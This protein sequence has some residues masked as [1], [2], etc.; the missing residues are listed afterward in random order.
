MTD[1]GLP[2]LAEA[3]AELARTGTLTFSARRRLWEA[4]G[5]YEA[6]PE[7]DPAPRTLTEPLQGRAM[8][9]LACARKVAPLWTL[10]APG[11]KRAERLI[12]LTGSYL[13]GKY[14]A[15][16]LS[17][18]RGVI[19]EFTALRNSEPDNPA[20]AAAIAAWKALM[21]ALYD[22]Q[23]LEPRYANAAD[24]DL[25]PSDW[26][27]ARNACAVWQEAGTD[28]DPAL[29][30]VRR[31]LFWAW[32]LEAAARLLGQE[33]FHFPKKAIAV[34]QE[35][36]SPPRPLPEAVTMETLTEYLG[37]G[38]YLYHVRTL[39]GPHG[40]P[41][42]YK[43]TAQVAGESGIC[44][45]CKQK[46]EHFQRMM[47]F[48]YLEASVPGARAPLC[49]LQQAPLFLCPEHPD[50]WC[51][52]PRPRVNPQLALKR[53]LS[54][55]GRTQAILLQLSERTVNACVV[56]DGSVMLNGSGKLLRTI[57]RADFP[58]RKGAS[59]RDKEKEEYEIDL[60]TFG[61]HV[62][63]D[64][65]PYAEFCRRFPQSVRQMEDGSVL[66]TLDRIW[67]RCFSDAAGGLERVVLR[68]RYHIWITD[69]AMH[70]KALPK[71][72]QTLIGLTAEQAAEQLRAAR[73]LPTR[74][75]SLPVLSGLEKQETVHLLALLKKSGI[76]CRALA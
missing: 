66:L 13:R 59:W 57:D 39:P 17:M 63:F 23:L 49:I 50:E 74:E 69:E 53:Y 18:E 6:R 54:K 40:E 52:P 41:I 42:T 12:R 7:D 51:F 61:P 19:Q 29:Q 30:A 10:Y 1:A 48:R 21:T 64:R 22:E 65:L 26:D 47:S 8:L 60:K 58:P 32:Y 24:S 73:Q 38:T 62:Y 16:R 5:P 75:W 71:A 44:P 33:G 9:A 72:L 67:A 36:Q 35:R 27:A 34:F 25:D 11:D 68:S 28:G 14:S 43:V 4:F 37:A 76:A 56:L 2:A 31:M 55:P 70:A 15:E 20:P 46:T 3:A 45:V